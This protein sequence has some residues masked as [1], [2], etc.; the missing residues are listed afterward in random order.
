MLAEE[1][2]QY[3]A[4]LK[5]ALEALN[6]GSGGTVIAPARISVINYVKAK[7]DE[8]LPEGEGITFSLSTAPNVSD[9]TN[10]L[11]NANLDESVKNV[12]LSA[13]LPVLFP[14]AMA[15]QSGTP[16]TD[17]KTGYVILPAN[18]LRLSSF[19]MADWQREVNIAISS[20]SKEYQRQSNK[21][22]RGGICKPIAALN[23]KNEAD[24]LKRII[25]YYSIDTSHLV[26]K[27]FYIPEQSAEDFVTVNPDLLPSLAW[28][29]AA[30][31]L[32]ITGQKI[33]A[34]MAME[35]VKLSY[36]GLS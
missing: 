6:I 21:Y 4:A 29:C 31:I 27:L 36:A 3:E 17:A 24:G 19:K 5:Q 13:P 23:W 2:I 7:L 8:L 15:P 16:F 33:A 1:R 14:T 9:P 18:F 25:E 28:M 34:E 20:Q 11:I 26:D 30:K 35:Q 12:I 22:H 32:Q 10:M